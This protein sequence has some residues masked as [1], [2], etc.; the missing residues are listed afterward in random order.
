[1]V[2][3]AK[4]Q[5]RSGELFRSNIGM[6][7]GSGSDGILMRRAGG[8][9][10]AVVEHQT[11]QDQAWHTAST[12]RFRLAQQKAHLEHEL[13]SVRRATRAIQSLRR[14]KKD[15]ELA[16][17]LR[18]AATPS[19][20]RRAQWPHKNTNAPVEDHRPISAPAPALSVGADAGTGT[21]KVRMDSLSTLSAAGSADHYTNTRPVSAASS[22]ASD[23]SLMSMAAESPPASAASATPLISPSLS[24]R[25]DHTPRL[26]PQGTPRILYDSRPI[27]SGSDLLVDRMAPRRTAESIERAHQ[28]YASP[29]IHRTLPLIACD[30]RGRHRLLRAHQPFEAESRSQ[31]QRVRQ[32]NASWELQRAHFAGS[33]PFAKYVSDCII[34]DVPTFVRPKNCKHA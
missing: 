13:R 16:T 10:N 18:P 6:W 1:M 4:A 8:T 30:D 12:R 28:S 20:K 22:S 27:G 34:K 25:Q 19:P 5:A 15:C 9:V 7:V 3:R 24:P 32:S 21:G 23:L 29:N 17:L 14:L 31:F 11:E 33:G 26:H 2:H